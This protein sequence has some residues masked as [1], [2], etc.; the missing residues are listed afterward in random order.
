[1]LIVRSVCLALVLAVVWPSLGSSQNLPAQHLVLVIDNSGS[2]SSTDPDG[3]RGVAGSLVLDS[4][5][6]GSDLKAAL[7]YF[8]DSS[9]LR[10][11]LSAPD[12]IREEMRPGR[13][14]EPGGGT[15]LEAGLRQAFGVLSGSTAALRR[16][17]VIT[18]GSPGGGQ[19]S[20]ILGTLVGQAQQDG[21]E[22][23]ALGLSE[24]VNEPFLKALT[25]PTRGRYRVCRKASE[26]SRGAKSLMGQLDNVYPLTEGES[27]GEDVSFRLPEG[28]DRARVTVV[29]ANPREFEPDT[30]KFSLAP[31]PGSGDRPY[32][33]AVGGAVRVA[34]WTTFFSK[35]GQ[36]TLSVRPEGGGGSKVPFRFF[37]EAL[38]ILEITIRLSPPDDPHLFKEQIQVDVDVRSAKGSIVDLDSVKVKGQ[39]QLPTGSAIDIP[40]QKWTGTFEVPDVPGQHTISITAETSSALGRAHSTVTYQARGYDAPIMSADPKELRFAEALGPDHP[41]IVAKLRL[42]PQFPDNR[43]RPVPLSFRVEA[44][45]SVGFLSMGQTRLRA[46]GKTEYSL[47]SEGAT[48]EVRLKLDA[49]QS[50]PEKSGDQVGT[51]KFFSRDAE[52]VEVPLAYKLRIPQFEV[53]SAPKRISLWWNPG[54]ERV[55]ALGSVHTDLTKA[56]H[57]WVEL[58]TTF[59][60]ADGVEAAEVSL[61]VDGRDPQGKV[62]RPSADRLRYG[63]IDLAPAGKAELSLVIRPT[64]GLARRSADSKR[65]SVAL[66]HE[67]GMRSKVESEFVL[68]GAW[69]LGP[70]HKVPRHGL[71]VAVAFWLLLGTSLV[72]RNAWRRGKSIRR[73]WP[74]RRGA[75]LEVLP[76]LISL[77]G[78]PAAGLALPAS[79]T[80]LDGNAIARINDDGRQLSV[81]G[82]GA[83]GVYVN[84]RPVDFE[85]RR[86]RSGDHLA[87]MADQEPL[88]E[89]EFVDYEA[90]KGEVEV[91]ANPEPIPIRRAI[92]KLMFGILFTALGVAVLSSDAVASLVYSIPGAESAYTWLLR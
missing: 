10:R 13:L 5:E 83:Q 30:V 82:L 6:L 67:L 24:A 48:F 40:F 4:A 18:D 88:W 16:I 71:A 92:R 55:A 54:R 12:E 53:V 91:I 35:P 17:V 49:K 38:S 26:L 1:V 56:S 32:L 3:L 34:A 43:P 37:V 31:D 74:F 62:E 75:L 51:I 19:E 20:T 42:V 21:I 46:D 52:K 68:V 36:Y 14:P 66:E 87:V 58:P 61:K 63:P 65:F 77:G 72:G 89:F 8:G 69:D 15:N 70:E 39:V 81:S 79:G 84:E 60:T 50:L 33:S 28:A 78:E 85:P 80:A 44:P 86:L 27:R 2:M 73:F 76:G 59:S 90:G 11:P 41:E 22:I 23:L 45:P 7:I 64:P 47:P 9:E 25:E 57:F 29:L